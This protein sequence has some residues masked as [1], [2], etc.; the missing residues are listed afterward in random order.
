MSLCAHLQQSACLHGPQEDLKGVLG[1]GAHQLSADVYCEGGEL[2]GPRRRECP[3]VSVPVQVERSDRPVQ[4]GADDDEAAGG[5]GDVG[6]A[7]GVLREGDEAEAAVGVPHFD[8]KR[9]NAQSLNL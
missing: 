2:R 3:E 9:M 4:G 5:E 6:D 8:L 7:A 1:S